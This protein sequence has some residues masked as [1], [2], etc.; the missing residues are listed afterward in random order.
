MAKTKLETVT[1]KAGNEVKIYK[2][3]TYPMYA[4]TEDGI[5][6]SMTSLK[7]LKLRGNAD[8]DKGEGFTGRDASDAT[9]YIYMKEFEKECRGE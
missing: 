9:T 6:F 1:D 7:E 5:P 4:L 8:S 2:S 3:K